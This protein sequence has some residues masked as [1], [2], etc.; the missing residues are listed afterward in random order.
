M[1]VDY[2]HDVLPLLIWNLSSAFSFFAAGQ[3]QHSKTIMPPT[4]PRLMG[5]PLS[6]PPTGPR[7]LGKP[8]SSRQRSSDRRISRTC[9]A[10]QEDGSECHATLFQPHHKLCSSHHREYKSLYQAYKLD[11]KDYDNIKI[12]EDNV[13][14]QELLEAKIVAGKKTIKLRD[15]VNRRFYSVAG[16]DNRSHVKW[17]LKLG[18][19][20]ENM[21]VRLTALRSKEPEHPSPAT[22]TEDSRPK[23]YQS[24]LDP[25]N[26]MSALSHLP[27][28]YPITV[29]KESYNLFS[30][31]LIKRLYRIVPS[32]ND[33]S[34][35]VI[36]LGSGSPREPDDGDFV[37]RFLF[38]ELLLYMADT[39]VLEIASRTDRIDTFLR[40]SPGQITN[41][42]RFFETFRAA[43]DSTFHLLRDA[44]CDYLLEPQTSYISLLGA[45][46]PTDQDCRSMTVK[47]WDILYSCFNG[48]ASWANLDL[49]AFQ[50]EDVVA[51]K[52]MVA[53]QRYGTADGTKESWYSPA[54][55]VSQESQLAVWQGFIPVLKG[56]C[57]PPT[58]SVTTDKGITTER[59]S[60]CYLVG[61]MSKQNI[62]AL[63]L[64]QELSERVVRF[65]VVVY[66]RGKSSGGDPRIVSPPLSD[67]NPWIT[68]SRTSATKEALSSESWNIEWSL[69]HILRDLRFVRNVTGRNMAED[70]YEYIIIDRMTDI[71]FEILDVVADALC[72]L[73]GDLP[74]SEMLG[75]VIRR[76]VPSEDQDEYLDWAAGIKAESPFIACPFTQL[77]LGNRIRCW[78]I[79]NAFQGT[80]RA[81]MQ[82][83][84]P[85]TPILWSRLIA[86]VTAELD[87][88]GAVTLVQ[89]FEPTTTCPVLLNGSDGIEDLYFDYRITPTKR[90]ALCPQGTVGLNIDPCS[91]SLPQF[92]EAYL[93]TH[94]DAVFTKGWINLPYCAWP[95]DWL[96][97][98][99]HSG[100]KFYTPEGKLYR[101]KALPFDFPSASLIWQMT[102]NHQFNN[103]LPFVRLVQTT[104]LICAPSRIDASANI[105]M[106]NDTGKRH[107][108]T[109]SVPSPASW[110][111]D[112]GSLHLETLW[113]GIRPVL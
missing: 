82:S 28:D 64:A 55:D 48:I 5:K 102:V 92:A 20:V 108:W 90:D 68:R 39:H 15:Q 40:L 60:R 65:M 58:P 59:L 44:V 81:R 97:K 103:K 34:S 43:H 101:W 4:G 100:L 30:E 72:K 71:S 96:S 50:F 84:A 31:E 105:K 16:D 106:L 27:P 51:V 23:V 91:N 38:R 86:K 109:F 74:Y 79:P 29:L 24:L 76:Y 18:D 2:D 56:F 80:L 77:Y 107:G 11:E 12:T 93:N 67:P 45:K 63:R 69:E 110:T 53:F 70:Y 9:A 99:E 1:S 111:A 19:D 32:L 36:D 13:E 54:D 78:D 21:E 112:I 73:N 26:P 104:L 42:I 61:R 35:T 62:S 6:R 25:A 88:H 49:F 87:A 14:I 47:G 89:K 52:T 83:E 95:T 85:R 37:I 17:L 57:D 113:K 94:P 22:P 7:L 46:I 75:P 33:S 10:L 41:Y 66:D 98:T 3:T 8:L